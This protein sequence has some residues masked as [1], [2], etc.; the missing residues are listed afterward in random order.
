MRN[1]SVRAVVGC[2][3]VA[4]TGEISKERNVGLK[5]FLKQRRRSVDPFR[6]F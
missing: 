2:Q 4:E 5:V 1:G 6:Y 3:L